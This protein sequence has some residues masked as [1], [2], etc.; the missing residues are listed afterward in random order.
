M[1]WIYC[2]SNSINTKQYVGKTTKNIDKR[3]KEHLSDSRK[4]EC[5]NRPLYNSICKYGEDKFKI[6][7][8][9]E[10]DELELN[11]WENFWIEKLDTYKNG[12]NATLG[13]DGS[14]LFNYKEIIKI[15]NEGFTIKDTAK[16]IG[17][18]IDTV[19]KVLQLYN[20]DSNKN[21]IKS[22][23]KK[24]NQLDMNNNFI[25]TFDSTMDAIKWLYEN[26][27]TKTPSTGNSS[28]LGKCANGKVKSAYKFKW[29]WE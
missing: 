3:F 10:C 18:C 5:N 9:Q 22:L 26:G 25:R 24:I 20:I 4:E 23:S 11:F 17:C 12:Y 7:I 28:H 1:A 16:Q 19:S 13:G 6:E 15:H 21:K 2:I 14:I 29:K 27:F 8:L